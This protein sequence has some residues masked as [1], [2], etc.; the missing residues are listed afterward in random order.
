MIHGWEY[1]ILN[2]FED[3]TE[4]TQDIYLS[5]Y[6]KAYDQFIKQLCIP[7]PN[8]IIN[9]GSFLYYINCIN[10]DDIINKD[11]NYEYKFLKSVFFEKKFKRIKKDLIDYYNEFNININRIYKT[12]GGYI[13][14]LTA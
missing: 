2:P 6:N 9:Q 13:I 5:R 12:T 10:N 3:I 11:D 1:F 14:E 8:D 7:E 4:I